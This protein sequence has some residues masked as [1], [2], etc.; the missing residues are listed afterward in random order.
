MVIYYIWPQGRYIRLRPGQERSE[1]LSLTL[2]VRQTRMFTPHFDK[3]GVIYA[4][5]LVIEIGYHTK[6]LPG[7]EDVYVMGPNEVIISALDLDIFRG[8]HVLQITV[9]GVLIPYEEVWAGYTRTKNYE[10]KLINSVKSDSGKASG[11]N[12]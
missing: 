7:I 5:R 4:R 11:Q 2:P 1:S 12:D 10:E 3:T 8:E 9:D 6:N